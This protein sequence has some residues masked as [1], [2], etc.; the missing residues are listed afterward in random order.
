MALR[1]EAKRIEVGQQLTGLTNV[2]TSLTERL[3]TLKQQ[4]ADLR[5]TAERDSA[6]DVADLTEIDAALEQVRL[7][8]RAAAEAF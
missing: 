8:I 2:G 3:T 7:D 5:A 4:F 6:F 1:T